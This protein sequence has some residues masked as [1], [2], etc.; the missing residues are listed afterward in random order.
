MSQRQSQRISKL[1][2]RGTIDHPTHWPCAGC[3]KIDGKKGKNG[4]QCDVC[5]KWWHVAC[6]SVALGPDLA[7]KWT[8]RICLRRA[9]VSASSSAGNSDDP[10]SLSQAIGAEL[11]SIRT[12]VTL[13]AAA[14]DNTD[15][16]FQGAARSRIPVPRRSI[17]A[18]AEPPCPPPTPPANPPLPTSSTPPNPRA[19]EPLSS[20]ASHITAPSLP[21]DTDAEIANGEEAT[22]TGSQNDHLYA[23]PPAPDSFVIPDHLPALE[24]VMRVRVNTIVFVPIGARNDVTRLFTEL[25]YGAVQNPHAIPKWT[26]IFLAPKC[27]LAAPARGGRRH[28][29][30]LERLIK[31]RIRRWR[32]GDVAHLWAEVK[33]PP[34]QGRRRAPK[35]APPSQEEINSRRCLRLVQAGQYSRAIN[36]LVSRGLD[37]GSRAA[38]VAMSEKHPPAP[39]PSFRPDDL[40]LPPRFDTKEV[41]KAVFSF[42]P[43]S[44]PGPSGLRPEH[45]KKMITTSDPA[46]GRKLLNALTSFTNLLFSGEFP[47]EIAPLLCGANLFAAIKKDGGHRPV[48]VGE[49]FRRL[50]SKCAAFKFTPDAVETLKPL[51]LGVGVRGGVEI[52]VHSVRAVIEDTS[53][54]PEEK[55][56]LQLDFQNAFNTMNRDCIFEETYMTLP[57]LMPWVLK[58]YGCQPLLNFGSSVLLSQAGVQQADPLASLLW[59]LGARRIQRKIAEKVTTG[60]HAQIWIHDDVTLIGTL[61][62]LREA[63]DITQREG[64]NI[65]LKLSSSKSLIWNPSLLGT[66]DPLQR[67]VPCASPD[68]FILLGAPVGNEAFSNM[69]LGKRIAKVEEAIRLLPTLNDSHVEFVLLRSCLS[70]PKFNFCLRTCNPRDAAP[71]Y[72]AF[73]GLLRDSLNSLLG[74]QVNHRQWIQASLPVSMGGIG[75]RNASPHAAGAYLVSLAHSLP[76]M[77]TIIPNGRAPGNDVLQLLNGRVAP[78]SAFSFDDLKD[79]A[80]SLVT[81]AIDLRIQEL[82]ISVALTSRDKARLACVS[83]DHSGDWL[84][85]LPS[86]VFNLHMPGPEFRVAIRYRLGVPVFPEDGDCPACG[87]PS[88]AFGDHA[89]A[90]GYQGERNSRHNIIR[91]EIYNTAKAAGLRPTKEERGIIDED[92]SRP[93]D[94]KI[95]MWIRGKDVAFDVTVCSPLSASYVERSAREAS[96]T[97]SQSFENKHRKHGDHCRRK[98]IVFYPLP[99]QT[100]GGWHPEA[101]AE[102]KRIGDALTKRAPGTTRL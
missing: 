11:R 6:A 14:A 49:I 94:V 85:A 16:A 84:N 52:A 82:L 92:E 20:T 79:K 74:T 36:A 47:S 57:Q 51:Q 4:I 87:S 24:E 67:S 38:I 37:Q 7:G 48:A 43:G 13:A 64:A 63:F 1:P 17:S 90:C 22:D 5:D 59:A 97:L 81:H 30:D 18:R 41:R 69:I 53:I 56:T 15:Q 70:L 25:L 9:N 28:H 45:L 96:H 89:I 93:A 91:D 44:A 32:D 68:G 34:P 73:D 21:T 10:P 98:N 31:D 33:T 29:K 88:D 83:L 19:P 58:A 77:Q 60:L 55:W 102:L 101:A 65:D 71:S 39:V 3:N 23:L 46:H 72:E 76:L 27:L 75:I 95:P 12:G 35:E 62:A 78:S 40:P 66:A 80:Q 86:F 8:C 26:L 2:N 99:V 50:V 61:P 100:L 54:P 42:N